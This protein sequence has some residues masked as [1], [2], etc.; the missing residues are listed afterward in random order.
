MAVINFLFGNRTPA[1]FSLSGVVEFDA[2]LT[3]DEQHE[4]SAEATQHPIEAG[5]RISDHVILSPDRL[6]ISGFVTDA[7]VAVLGSQPGRTQSAFDTLDS[8]WRA[9]DLVQVVT[10]YRTYQDMIITR[11]DMPRTRPESMQFSIEF[12]HIRIVSSEETELI[13]A[14][15]DD[16]SDS[17]SGRKNAGRQ[18]VT[19][20]GS[21]TTRAG[22]QAQ[23]QSTLAGIF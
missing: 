17:A 19:E 9:R 21:A 2:D 7:G 12:Q 18:P 3:I 23:L 14:V 6:S 13:N 11:L 15:D 16:V 1:G 20:A 5:A 8:A 4:R 22:E 10:G